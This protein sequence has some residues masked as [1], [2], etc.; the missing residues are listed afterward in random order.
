MTEELE[1]KQQNGRIHLRV[2]VSP[3]ARTAR[4]LGVHG[5]ALKLSVCEPPE[6]GKANDGVIRLLSNLLGV[7]TGQIE[8]VSGHTSQDKR[9]AIAGLDEATLHERLASQA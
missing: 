8:L 9:V 3:G 4:L 1:L 6:R 2:R 7:T 5:G